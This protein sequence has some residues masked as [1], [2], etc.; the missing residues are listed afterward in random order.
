MRNAVIALL[1]VLVAGLVWWQGGRQPG[2]VAPAAVVEA[3]GVIPE[4]TATE[5]GVAPAVPEPAEEPVAEAPVDFDAQVE[6]MT[7]R[8]SEGLEVETLPDGS[9]KIDLQGRYRQAPVARVNDEGEAEVS[10]Q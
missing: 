7:R 1:V 6:A 8:D 4:V 9:K 3:P 2:Q 10:E 5:P